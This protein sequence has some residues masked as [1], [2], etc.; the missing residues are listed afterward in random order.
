MEFLKKEIEETAEDLLKTAK[1]GA[2]T[3]YQAMD[4]ATKIQ[5]N[6]ILTKILSEIVKMRLP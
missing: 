4:L 1:Y 3:V 5:Q 2:L 6:Q